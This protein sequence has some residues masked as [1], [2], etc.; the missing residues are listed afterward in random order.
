MKLNRI[1]AALTA[2]WSATALVW[3]DGPKDNIATDVRPVPPLGIPVPDPQKKELET[4][5]QALRTAIDAAAKAQ[6]K[7]PNIEDLL[8]DVEV[9]HK[10]VDWALRHNEFFKPDEF[11]GAVEVLAEGMG[12]AQSLLKGETPWTKQT[13]LVVRGYKSKIDGSYQPYGMVVPARGFDGPRRLDIWCHGRFENTVE[14]GFIQQRRKQ[15]GSIQPEGALV[16]HPFGRFSCANKFAGEI[17]T[18]E[19]LAHARKFYPIDDDRIMMRGFSMGGAAAWQFATHYAGLWCGANPGAG[20]AETPEFLRVFQ[21]EDVSTTPWYEQKLWHW[22]NST[23]YALN[24]VQCPTVAYSGEIDKQKQAADMMEKALLAEQI[25]MVHIIGPQT[26]H[27]IHPDSLVEI[28]RRLNDIASW[29]RD[30]NPSEIHFTTWTL[31]YNE[32]KWLKVDAL[33]EHWE[34]SRVHAQIVGPKH[35][36]LKTQGVTALTIDMPSGHCSFPLVEKPVLQVD[37]Q[38]LEVSRPKLD[39]SWIV[40]LRKTGTK[41]AEVL[42]PFDGDA[43]AKKHG[44][45]GPIDDAFMSAFLFVKPTGAPISAESGAWVKAELDHA[46]FEWRRQFRGDAPTKDDKAITDADIANNNLVLWGDPSSNAVLARIIDKLPLKWSK[47]ALVMNGNTTDGSK[48][49]PVMI[50]PNPLNPNKYVVL[51]SS[52]TY[53]E[54][55]YL[56]NARQAPKLPDWAVIDAINGRDKRYPGKTL[57]AGFFGEKWEWVKRK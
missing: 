17:D 33:A 5:V 52:F 48:T 35:M 53:R 1:A 42:K 18:F 23:D 31:R 57:D 34:R 22:Y 21:N 43:L 15:V 19:A 55:D 38:E 50:F 36:L 9:Y 25:D 47:E 28:E 3:A 12:R 51:N 20:F 45:Q 56:N 24:L 40:H 37:G 30:R 11:K 6:A 13:G 7:M 26:A 29:G 4:A 39:R 32:M 49:V 27:K 8:A 14:L 41:W 46:Q 44:L 2:A 16:L 10:A 54:Y